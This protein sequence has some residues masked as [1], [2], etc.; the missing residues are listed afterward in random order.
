[1]T[2]IRVPELVDGELRLRPPNTPDV[3]AI[4]SICRDVEVQRWTRVPP[5]YH[6][7]HARDFVVLARRG[8][9]DGTGVHLLVVDAEDDRVLGAV[10]LSIDPADFTGDLGYWVAP[11]AR[12]RGVATRGA[13]LLARFGLEELALGYI[14]LHAAAANA[15]SNA[16]ARRLG[17]THEGTMRSAMIDGPAGDRTAPRC[18]ARLWGLRPG[19][20]T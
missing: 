8:L 19:E 18:D 2:V 17:F 5:P 7:R 16:V 20:L 11:S 12:G 6:E 3:P 15:P 4:T 14:S 13:R 10:G 1:V 9:G